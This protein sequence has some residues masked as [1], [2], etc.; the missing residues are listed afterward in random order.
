MGRGETHH[1]GMGDRHGRRGKH[2]RSIRGKN[3]GRTAGVTI[4]TDT[5]TVTLTT[6]TGVAIRRGMRGMLAVRHAIRCT[7]HWRRD[8]QPAPTG[9]N[10]GKRRKDSRWH[11]ERKPRHEQYP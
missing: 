9:I 5:V 10:A 4:M 2:A 1:P 3:P 8:V 7:V 6:G 11:G